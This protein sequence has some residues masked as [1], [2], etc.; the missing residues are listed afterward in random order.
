MKMNKDIE[1]YEVEYWGGEFAGPIYDE[2]EN[3]VQPKRRPPRTKLQQM[4]LEL[5]YDIDEI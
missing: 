3:M 5:E 4:D 1:D 2:Q